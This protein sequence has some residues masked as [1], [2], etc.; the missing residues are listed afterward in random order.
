M[1]ICIN[2]VEGIFQIGDLGEDVSGV[3]QALCL[4]VQQHLL[5]GVLWILDHLIN[6]HALDLE[7]FEGADICVGQNWLLRL[8]ASHYVHTGLLHNGKEV[9]IVRGPAHVPAILP[10]KVQLL[11]RTILWGHRFHIPEAAVG[12]H[13]NVEE[14]KNPIDVNDRHPRALTVRRNHLWAAADGEASLQCQMWQGISLHYTTLPRHKETLLCCTNAC[15]WILGGRGRRHEAILVMSA[16]A[17]SKGFI[18]VE[19]HLGSPLL[20]ASSS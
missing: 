7:V 8:Q 3:S 5:A 4:K 18:D 16:R 2:V 17:R 9:R 13:L 20:H 12:F 11:S 14:Q 15:D 10:L 1:R 6:E 19:H